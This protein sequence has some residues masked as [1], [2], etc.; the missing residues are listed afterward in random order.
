MDILLIAV[1][2]G[3]LFVGYLMFDKFYIQRKRRING[4]YIRILLF[5]SVG[6][7]KTFKGVFQGVELNDD[8]IGAYIVIN[9][10]KKAISLVSST[11]FFYDKEFGRALM[12][13]KFAEDD[14]R[15]MSSLK[16]ETWFKVEE[17]EKPDEPKYTP[18]VEPIGIT[19]DGRTAN[20]FNRAFRRR[21][22][23]LRQEKKGWF[24]QYGPY[25]MMAGMMLILLI[26]TAYNSNKFA[27]ASENMAEVFAEK[28]DE[29]LSEI[30]SPTFAEKLLEQVERRN[31]EENA[32]I[33]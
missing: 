17:G 11:D 24:E 5:E 3:V 29:Y 12:V 16:N 9:K 20:R 31:A 6:K 7:D 2:I 15:A 1:I 13:C 19:V 23:A 28:S 8:V 32:P 10:V 27:E 25:V 4:Q 30:E 18:Y 14:Y 26:S 22:E 21:M 33:S